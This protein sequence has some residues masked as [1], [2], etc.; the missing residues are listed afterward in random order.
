M[1]ISNAR[2]IEELDELNWGTLYALARAIDAKSHWTAGHSERVT[3]LALRIGQALG[4]NQN[5]TRMICIGEGC[6][7]I[8][9]RSE[10]LRRFLI[11][12]VN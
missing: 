4:L 1:A 12:P 5:T 10:F 7:T 9:A 8:L 11:R 2:L 6:C 3:E